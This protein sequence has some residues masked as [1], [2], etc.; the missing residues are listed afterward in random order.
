[1]KKCFLVLFLLLLCNFSYAQDALERLTISG[2]LKSETALNVKNMRNSLDKFKNILELSGEYKLQGDELVLFTKVKYW[3]DFAYG[4][5]DKLDRAQHYMA[6]VQ[7][8]DWL[9]DF[10]LDYTRGNWFFRIGKQQV[11]WGQ[12]DGIT[13]LDRINPVDLSEFWLPDFVDL[14]IPLWMVN[15]NYSPKT[16]SNLQLLFIPDFQQSEAAFL[17][18]P[19]CFRSFKEFD[20]F[21]TQQMKVGNRFDI[22]LNMPGH[23]FS[24]AAWGVQWS[25]RIEKFDVDYTLNFL[26]SH[27]PNARNLISTRVNGAGPNITY[28]VNRNFPVWRIYGASFNKTVTKPGLLQGF[29]F[30]GDFAYYND[31]PT[32]FGSPTANSTK[33]YKRW[34]NKFWVIGVDKNLLTRWTVSAQFGQYILEHAKVGRTVAQESYPMNPYTYGPMDQVEN[35]FSLKIGSHFLNDRLLTEVSWNGTDDPQGRLSPKISYEIKNNFWVTCG[36]HY[37]YGNEWD[38]N[39]Q[40]KDNSE[41]FTNLKYSF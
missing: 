4:M 25:D 8:T 39:G 33:G 31:E 37:F 3:Y 12:A 15:I 28:V 24:D 16:N 6:H 22:R 26:Y 38:T 27:Y 11:A 32:Y 18:A 19:F 17:G 1:M 5:R 34:D 23:G 2:Y 36:F 20:N 41:F 10:Y 14:R 40:F 7:R 30:R 13:V 35:I 9:R 21:M 29:T